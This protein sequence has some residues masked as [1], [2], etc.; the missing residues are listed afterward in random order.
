[1]QHATIDRPISPHLC[2]VDV[3]NFGAPVWRFGASVEFSIETMHGNKPIIMILND[4]IT[5]LAGESFS[6]SPPPPTRAISPSPTFFSSRLL[7]LALAVPIMQSLPAV[8]QCNRHTSMRL[9]VP[10]LF[11]S[12]LTGPVVLRSAFVLR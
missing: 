12:H 2:S 9:P 6:H 5:W 10:P 1:M 8:C 4:Y 11:L 3:K 7:S